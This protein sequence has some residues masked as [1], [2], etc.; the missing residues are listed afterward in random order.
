MTDPRPIGMFDSGIGGLT[1]LGE[2]RKRLPAESIVYLG[3][4]ARV[5]YGTKSGRTVAR[6]SVNNTRLLLGAGVK[7]IVVACNTASSYAM[8]DVAAESEAPVVGVVEGGVR[9]AVESG[10]ARIGVIGTEATIR[11]G[12]Y[13]A[14]IKALA[15]D[16]EVISKPCPLFVSL[17][18]EGWTDNEVA[19]AVAREYLGDLRGRV[20]A[21]VLACTHYPLLKKTIAGVMGPG[22]TLIDSAEQTAR[23][24]A[25]KIEADGLAVDSAAPGRV[26]FMVTDSP[27]RSLRIG[28]RMLGGDEITEVELVDLS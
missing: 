15:P 19:R 21:L 25:G 13:P 14:R 23:L 20:D 8:D 18:E 2:I 11:S 16:A 22:V 6:Y 24:V 26:R 17:V 3:D 5:P 1:V 4:T 10:S 27:E 9:A 12:A 28:K 7:M